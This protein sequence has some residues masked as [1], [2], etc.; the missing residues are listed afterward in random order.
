MRILQTFLQFCHAMLCKYRSKV[1]DIAKKEQRFNIV[2]D[3]LHK[4]PIARP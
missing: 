3:L 1:L 2:R 4:F